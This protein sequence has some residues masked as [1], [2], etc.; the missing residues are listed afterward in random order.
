M[1]KAAPSGAFESYS[2]DPDQ[3]KSS[4]RSFGRIMA[5]FL[6]IV[7]GFQFHHDRLVLATVLALIGLAFAVLAQVR[8]Q[9]LHRLNLLWFRFGLLL[10]KVVNPLVMA[11]I[12]LGAVVPTA[13]VMRLLGKRPL[14]LAFDRGAPTYWITRQPPGPTGESMARQF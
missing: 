3:L 1:P 5:V 10:H 11:V 7:S 4:D 13:L 6:L 12:F 9:A 2:R 8:P 14:A